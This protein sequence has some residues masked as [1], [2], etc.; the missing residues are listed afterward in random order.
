MDQTS[1]YENFP[2][3]IVLICN[4]VPVTIYVIGILI[5]AGFGIGV[6]ALYLILCL[7]LEYRLLKVSCV[8]CY[9]YGKLCGFGKGKLCSLL[10]K[11]GDPQRFVERTAS[12]RD[13]L[14]DFLVFLLPVGGGIVLLI[15]DFEWL[16][17]I[18]LAVLVVLSFGGTALVRGS[19]SCQYCKQKDIGCPA[20]QLFRNAR[21]R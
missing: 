7:G 15:Q 20:E 6:S 13:M 21:E 9:Y 16:L 1:R 14:P 10:F 4:L 3:A 19:F 11:K 18:A 17:V 5:L 2:P 8:S 12:W